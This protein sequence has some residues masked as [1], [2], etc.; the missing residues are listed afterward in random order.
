MSEVGGQNFACFLALESEYD[1]I[2]FTN[3]DC[4]VGRNWVSRHLAWHEHGYDMVGG[5]VFWGG[6]E[7]GFS[8]SYMTPPAPTNLLTSGLSLGFSNCSVSIALFKKVGPLKEMKA[9]QDM[10]FWIRAIK[11]GARMA[12]D[13]DIEIY[14]DHPMRSI[15]GSWLRSFYYGRNHVILLRSGFGRTKW[16]YYAS[17]PYSLNTLQD[18]TMVRGT[19]IWK[20]QRATAEKFRIRPGLLRFLFLKFFAFKTANVFGWIMGML[21]PVGKVAGTEISDAHIW[22]RSDG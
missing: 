3:S 7:Y 18:F 11:M 16:P 22:G 20:Q 2:L 9:H 5:K 17:W 1:V 15:K 8:W 12:L 14:H 4:Y 19:R 13:P 6:D 21:Y 10:D